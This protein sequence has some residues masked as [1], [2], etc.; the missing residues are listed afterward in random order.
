MLLHY[1]KYTAAELAEVRQIFIEYADF[2]QVDLCFQ[3]FEEELKTLHQVYA[4][5]QGCIILAKESDVI[6]GCIALKP[7]AEGVCEMKR[8]YVRPAAQGKQ[9][10]KELV[11]A[12]I[13]F[14]K[15]AGYHTM[16]LDTLTTLEKA[17]G[18][19]R[20][21]GFIETSA[22]VYNPLANV[23]YFELSL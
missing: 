18:L 8:L 23:L 17:I 12:L 19:Y 2:L 7:I 1:V 10:G 22:Y 4:P 15:N 21:L 6:L 16:K 14:A 9:V 5:P 3:S 13:K 11:I 20:S